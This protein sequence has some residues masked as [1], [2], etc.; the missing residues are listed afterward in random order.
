[1]FLCS[2]LVSRAE[3][4]ASKIIQLQ[5]MQE[6]VASKSNCLS[7][8]HWIKLTSKT[9]AVYSSNRGKA[10]GVCGWMSGYHLRTLCVGHGTRALI[11]FQLKTFIVKPS[12][13][14]EV[15]IPEAQDVAMSSEID[16]M[17]SNK[18]TDKLTELGLLTPLSSLG[19]IGWLTS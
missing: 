6:T 4:C 19:K 16:T 2:E 11:T 10:M 13:K 18:L 5:S 17:L 9:M 3:S 15:K 7:L 12:H 8:K 1:M 14:Y